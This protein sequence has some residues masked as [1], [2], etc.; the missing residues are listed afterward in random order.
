LTASGVGGVYPGNAIGVL[1]TGLALLL[2]SC[3]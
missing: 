3:L 2:A 1:A